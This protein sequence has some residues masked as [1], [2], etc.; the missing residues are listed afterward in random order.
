[1]RYVA[2]LRGIGPGDPRMRNEKLR[3]VFESLGLKNVQ[4]VIASGNIIF[5]APRAAGLEKQIE[6][7]LFE[8]LGF[9]STTVIRSQTSLQQLIAHKPFGDAMHSTNQY[10]LVTFLKNKPLKNKPDALPFKLPLTTADGASV[11]LG[12]DAKANAVFTCTDATAVKTPD[13]MAYLEKQLGKAITSRSWNSVQ[14]I[15]KRLE[16]LVN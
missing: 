10:L 5:S 1:M 6:D 2:L 3:A 13:V 4:S 15:S 11:V 8:Q 9:H 7:A 16:Q 12:Y 14:R